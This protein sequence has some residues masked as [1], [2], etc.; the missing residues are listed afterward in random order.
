MEPS[1]YIKECQRTASN[2]FHAHTVE[3][4][5]FIYL[6]EEVCNKLNELDGFKKALF[7][8]KPH[9]YVRHN[10]NAKREWEELLPAIHD[11]KGE[12]ILHGIIGV[13]T[14]SGELI[15]TLI[16]LANGQ[17][18]LDKVNLK[19]ELGDLLWYVAIICHAANFSFEDIMST[20]NAKLRKRF[21]EK[22]SEELAINRDLA[23]EREVLE[24]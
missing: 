14:E 15:E 7:Y 23:A 16:N 11:D 18:V 1:T 5:Q 2:Y 9:S 3:C 10:I 17:K 22:F 8:G 20:N 12:A 13:A 4:G 21:P 24:R 6:I 19:E